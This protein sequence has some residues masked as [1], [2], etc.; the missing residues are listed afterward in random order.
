MQK[1]KWPRDNEGKGKS[2]SYA[3]LGSAVL[4]VS[5]GIHADLNKVS[6]FINSLFSSFKTRNKFRSQA[7]NLSI[8]VDGNSATAWKLLAKN[9]DWKSVVS[10]TYYKMMSQEENL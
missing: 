8:A 3:R 9:C 2:F 7:Q 10:S 6:G 5:V 1:T 4:A